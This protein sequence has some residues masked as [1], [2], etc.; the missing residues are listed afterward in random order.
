MLERRT[1][2]K[3][4]D[5]DVY[6]NIVGGLKVSDPAADLAI[7]M[8]VASAAKGM[9]LKEDAAVFGELGLSGEIR[10]VSWQEKRLKEIEKLGFKSA[11]GPRMPKG[12]KKPA[13]YK[14]VSN[15]R[16]ALNHFL[17]KG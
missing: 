7:V 15:I 13:W 8:A 14:E 12:V 3:L 2:L 17:T 6:I 1:K 9:Q 4:Q 11:I 10:R 5:K 16:D